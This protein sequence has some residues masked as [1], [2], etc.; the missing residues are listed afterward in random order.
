MP[1]FTVEASV[2]GCSGLSRAFCCLVAVGRAETSVQ[3]SRCL[4]LPS[5]YLSF[6]NNMTF[7]TRL[8]HLSETLTELVSPPLIGIVAES[9]SEFVSD[10]KV[11]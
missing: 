1:L 9:V 2:R 8:V 7:T 11:E 5:S 3:P 6:R 10:G 4:T